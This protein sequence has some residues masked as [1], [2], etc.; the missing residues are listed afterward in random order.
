MVTAQEQV[1]VFSL[2]MLG[3]GKKGGGSTGHHKARLQVFQSL[4]NSAELSPEQT[5]Q[6]DFFKTQWDTKMAAIHGDGWGQ[7]FAEIVQKVVDELVG[8]RRDA[9]SVFMRNETRRVLG[10]VPALVLLGIRRA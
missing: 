10:A 3:H 6:C 5:S 4:R 9:L 7:L 2:D 8:G 1:K